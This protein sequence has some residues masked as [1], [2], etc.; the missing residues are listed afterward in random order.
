[1]TDVPRRP[2]AIKLPPP[3]D[4]HRDAVTD[5]LTDVLGYDAKASWTAVRLHPGYVDVV[6]RPRPGVQVTQRHAVVGRELDD[7]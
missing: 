2:R 7:A 6:L 5:F 3:V 4:V 1:V